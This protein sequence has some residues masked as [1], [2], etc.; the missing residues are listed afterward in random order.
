MSGQ[1]KY[2][3]ITYRQPFL[4]HHA[5]VSLPG[6]QRITTCRTRSAHRH[7]TRSCAVRALVQQAHTGPSTPHA[8]IHNKPHRKGRETQRLAHLHGR[9]GQGAGKARHRTPATSQHAASP[10]LLPGVLLGRCGRDLL[11]LRPGRHSQGAPL[12][13][14]NGSWRRLKCA[15]RFKSRL[16]PP[17]SAQRQLCSLAFHQNIV[18]QAL[19]TGPCPACNSHSARLRADPDLGTHGAHT[20]CVVPRARA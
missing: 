14:H 12:Q 16:P 13:A 4:V 6:N 18:S 10:L 1:D 8:H 11:P 19:S 17:E 3:P 2:K 9:E 5:A 15:V 20:R 7:M